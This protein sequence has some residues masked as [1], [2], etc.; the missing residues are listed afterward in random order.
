M[1]ISE[2]FITFANP[3][4]KRI[5]LIFDNILFATF[6]PQILMF[7][8]FVACV[9]ASYLYPP[10]EPEKE[11]MSEYRPAT[12]VADNV[13]HS[14]TFLFTD[15]D[16]FANPAVTQADS[17]D[18]NIPHISRSVYPLV[19]TSLSADGSDFLLFTRPPPVFYKLA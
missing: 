9:S 12:I 18:P 2:L 14:K 6:I 10:P 19:T 3:I 13:S 16:F 7:L 8:G 15:Y 1:K 4:Q 5:M 17:S 11:T